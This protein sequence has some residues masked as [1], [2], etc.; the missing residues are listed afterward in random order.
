MLTARWGTDEL[1]ARSLVG[2]M[3]CVRLPGADLEVYDD[4]HN[5][6]QDRLHYDYQVEVPIKVVRKRLYVRISAHLYNT[7]E[8]Y[9]RLADAVLAIR[10]R[11]DT[12]TPSSA[13][14]LSSSVAISVSSP[15]VSSSSSGGIIA[16]L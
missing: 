16:R 2:P 13:A 6:I 4:E 15:S 9:Y 12:C 5:D 8:D 11:I 3:I 14:S 7:R 10:P 1:A